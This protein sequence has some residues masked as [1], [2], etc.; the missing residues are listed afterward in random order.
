MSEPGLSSIPEA[1]PTRDSGNILISIL[2]SE[3][4]FHFTLQ[5]RKFLN[6]YLSG[7]AIGTLPHRAPASWWAQ[8]RLN[9]ASSYGLNIVFTSPSP[10]GGCREQQEEQ[11]HLTHPAGLQKQICTF[12]A[13]MANILI[14]FP[15]RIVLC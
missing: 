3:F 1:G 9:I 7:R 6:V 13:R 2:S 5:S 14:T 8:R 10:A 4:K 15:D 12:P 11:W